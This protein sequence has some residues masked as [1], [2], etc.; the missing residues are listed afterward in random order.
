[1]IKDVYMP[2][3]YERLILDV[4]LGTQTVTCCDQVSNY[5]VFFKYFFFIIEFC[6]Y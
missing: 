4:F 3:A 6:A 1:M 5:L 2:D